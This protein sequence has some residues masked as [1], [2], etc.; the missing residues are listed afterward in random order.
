MVTAAYSCV[1]IRPH[2][3]PLFSLSCLWI[4]EYRVR[5]RGPSSLGR[6]ACIWLTLLSHRQCFPSSLQSCMM[7]VGGISQCWS[8]RMWPW[9]GSANSAQMN[10]I[11]QG[12]LCGGR[13]IPRSWV[14]FITTELWLQLVWGSSD[15][16][17][18]SWTWAIVKSPFVL[19]T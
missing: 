18:F 5:G 14:L 7:V 19:M 2:M 15:P 1:W 4:A 6:R 13:T 3:V 17:E 16:G 10:E 8:Q 9:P 11:P 12:A